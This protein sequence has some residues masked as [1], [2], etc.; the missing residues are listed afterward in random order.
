M[1]N[2]EYY[3]QFPF[4]LSAWQKESIT[5]LINGNNSIVSAPTGSGKTVPAEFGIKYFTDNGKKVVYTSPIKA[6]S[7]EKYN[8][9]SNKYP[10][11]SFGLITGDNNINSHAD[12]LFMTQEIFRNTLDRMESQK[13]TIKNIKL[14]FEM[15]IE[16]ELGLLCMD[17][18]HWINDKMRGSAW[19]D[20]LINLPK[21]VA[22]LGLSATVNNPELF[23]KKIEILTRKNTLLSI[24]KKR[25]VPLQHNIFLT[26]PNKYYKKMNK[27]MIKLADKFYNQGVMIKSETTPFD[28][29]NFSEAKQI[30]DYLYQNKIYV[31]K[32]FAINEMVKYMVDN[33]KLP[34]LCYIFSRRKCDEY[35]TKI[36]VPLF[37]KGS[38][39]PHTIAKEAKQILI[40]KVPNWKEYIEMEEYKNMIKLLEKGIAVHHGG[41][42]QVLREI[43][44][45]LFSKKY[46]KLLFSTE[47][48]AI[49]MNMPTRSTIFVSLE[50]FDGDGMRFL[51][52]PE[53][54]QAA[55]RGGRRGKDTHSDAYHLINLFNS[56][57]NELTPEAYSEILSG[58]AQIIKYDYPI[59]FDIILRLYSQGNTNVEAFIKK[60]FLWDEIQKH[61]EYLK[62][63]KE[64]AKNDEEK[65]Y[66]DRKIQQQLDYIP[67]EIKKLT[68][69]LTHHTFIDNENKLTLKG[70]VASQL[71]EV[72][73]LV[74]SELLIENI[75]EDLDTIEIAIL[76]SCFTHVR[77][78]DENTI[79]HKNDIDLPDKIYNKTISRLTKIENK[80]NKYKDIELFERILDNE[81]KYYIHYNLA[82]SIYY[83]CHS[84]NPQQCFECYNY[85]K[86]YGLSTGDFIKSI[87]KI[88]NIAKE[89][90]KICEITENLA[91]LDKIKHIPNLL[92]KSIV[93]NQTIYS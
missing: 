32:Y 82:N 76:L 60:S 36:Q 66:I 72:N 83:W 10:N 30:L 85:M 14:D 28:G 16:N 89:L 54:T 45:I 25:T 5:N 38:S 92:L 62:K 57:N 70:K 78:T 31:N 44:E 17:E 43:I 77:L 15:D 11:I 35:A 24:H 41:V 53:Y 80:L 47:T 61:C 2:Q 75:F 49:G 59:N 27:P 81:E 88:C 12:V 6:L 93:T 84:E 56:R 39:I 91:L 64:T 42:I 73:N 55:G 4:E 69:L 23:A 52:P 58:K 68:D 46:I 18:V 1:D 34:A 71:N 90:E 87:L 13:D 50:K 19:Q 7:N 8:D 63:E 51:T 65:T 33:D 79:H 22:L 86:Q 29:K 37:E 67:Y 48:L 20:S 21:S 40:N 3:K 74:F 26:F 9:F